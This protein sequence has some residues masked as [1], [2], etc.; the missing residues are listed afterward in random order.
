MLGK[1][2]LTS[3]Y[4]AM[5]LFNNEHRLCNPRLGGKTSP[6]QEGVQRTGYLAREVQMLT[7]SCLP[8]TDPMGI[9]QVTVAVIK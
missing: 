6:V 4:I 7:Q 2:S 9:L 5:N 3:K 8:G 1:I